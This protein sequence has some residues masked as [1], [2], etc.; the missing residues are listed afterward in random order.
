[1]LENKT[2]IIK[3]YINKCIK[4]NLVKVFRASAITK[5]IE[6][7]TEKEIIDILEDYIKKGIIRREYNILCSNCYSPIIEL[8]NNT[9][10]CIHCNKEVEE[11]EMYFDE[12]FVVNK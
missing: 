9:H 1:M 5:K 2:D 8:S 6:G 11:E 10:Y 7:V 3:E 4:S 12:I